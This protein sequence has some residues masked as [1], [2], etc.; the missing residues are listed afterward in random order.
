MTASSVLVAVAVWVAIVLVG[1]KIDLDR[2][3]D[4]ACG[5]GMVL[6]FFVATVVGLSV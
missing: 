2:G 6:G 5:T 4:W 3:T 1:A